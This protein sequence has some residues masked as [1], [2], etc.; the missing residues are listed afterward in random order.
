M[1]TLKQGTGRFV[2]A[3]KFRLVKDENITLKGFKQ[4]KYE[5]K[6]SV[7]SALGTCF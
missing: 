1:G 6:V 5:R 7:V 3:G 4:L 2:A